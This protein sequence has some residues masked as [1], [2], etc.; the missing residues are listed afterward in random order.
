VWR[1]QSQLEVAI[2]A[3]IS[4]YNHQ[5]LH[6]ALGDPPPAEYETLADNAVMR[7]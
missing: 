2:A 1:T 6:E 4:W 3:Y 7:D 5:R